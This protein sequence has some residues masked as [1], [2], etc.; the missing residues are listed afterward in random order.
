P[1]LPSLASTQHW[2]TGLAVPDLS[3]SRDGRA[4]D[5]SPRPA[6]QAHETLAAIAASPAIRKASEWTQ[7][8]LG[9]CLQ[10][11]SRAIS[12]PGVGLESAING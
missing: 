5:Q 8:R 7:A 3:V 9:A 1:G 12:G 11:R 2:N 10:K 6:R 4:M